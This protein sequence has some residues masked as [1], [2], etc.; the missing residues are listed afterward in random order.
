M[1]DLLMKYGEALSITAYFLPAVI[2]LA[3]LFAVKKK[4]IWMSVPI[5][6]IIDLIVFGD[7][8]IYNFGEFRSIALVFL[9]PQ[10]LITAIISSSILWFGIRKKK[11]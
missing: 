1:T 4:W 5:V 9:I 2:S 8:L 6:V 3:V 11:S 10:I 7:A